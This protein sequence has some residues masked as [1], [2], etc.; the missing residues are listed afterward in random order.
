MA[1][2]SPQLVSFLRYARNASPTGLKDMLRPIVRR[3]LPAEL[4]SGAVA[5]DVT[6]ADRWVDNHYTIEAYGRKVHFFFLV[7]CFKS[8]TNWVQN[9][10]TLHPSVQIRGEFHFEV[11]H[12][13]MQHMLEV[14]WFL[15]ASPEYQGVGLDA[16]EAMIRRMI[17]AA[18]RDKPGATWLGDRSPS[19]LCPVIRGS[20]QILI[21]RDAR[22]VLV[23][24]SFHHMR[25]KDE[26]GIAVQFRDRWR[27]TSPKFRQDP[28]AFNTLDGL[29]GDE[30]WLRF[31]ARQWMETNRRS[32]L[33]LPQVRA[34]GAPVLELKYE[35][36]HEDLDG[37][38][39]KLYEFF[40]LDPTL[41]EQP[42]AKTKTLP[43]FEKENRKSFFRKGAVGDW[44]HHFDERTC[45]V[46]KEEAGEELV[47]CGYEKDLSW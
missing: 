4:R 26:N 16:L 45:R 5:P 17:Y 15:G 47:A 37:H 46:I 43:G 7:G 20:P 22:D 24:W 31:H 40:D 9:L 19:P 39:K 44:R 23:S 33:A 8:G 38:R 12:R 18:T 36:M 27:Q 14:D 1:H 10:L 11:L 30:Q 25:L 34:D 13:A 6:V 42:S 32:R 35:Q 21:T 28:D 2:L 41:A 3:V 29:L